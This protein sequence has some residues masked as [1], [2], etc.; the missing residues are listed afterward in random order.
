M[1]PRKVRH[2]R[3]GFIQIPG[4]QHHPDPAIELIDA[5]LAERIVLPQHGDQPFAV[6][7]LSQ[8]PGT[9]TGGTRHSYPVG[10]TTTAVP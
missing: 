1:K 7:V 3:R 6:G 5:E 9:T 4:P 8:P 10:R 2:R